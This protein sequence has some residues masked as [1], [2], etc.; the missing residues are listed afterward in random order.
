MKYLIRCELT[1]STK[2][3]KRLE[4]QNEHSAWGIARKNVSG[5][6]LIDSAPNTSFVK[7]TLIPREVDTLKLTIPTSNG[8]NKTTAQTQI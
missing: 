6:L 3:Q 5:T 8:M 2:D 4:R 7:N 1:A